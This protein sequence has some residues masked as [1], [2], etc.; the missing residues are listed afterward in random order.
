MQYFNLSAGISAGYL[1]DL[2]HQ[3]R[4]PT[5]STMHKLCRGLGI[6]LR[7]FFSDERSAELVPDPLIERILR[8][9][10]ESRLRVDRLLDELLD[11]GK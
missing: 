3:R 4:N 2:E 1:S 7:E 11:E 10:P 5:L 8:L 9:D 6:S